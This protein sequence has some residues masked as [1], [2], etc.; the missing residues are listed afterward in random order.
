MRRNRG[1]GLYIHEIPLEYFAASSSMDR[2]VVVYMM[3]PS[4]QKQQRQFRLDY[5]EGREFDRILICG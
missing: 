5:L 3:M 1:N 2:Q 4:I